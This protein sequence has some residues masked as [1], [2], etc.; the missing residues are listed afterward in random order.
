MKHPWNMLR[1]AEIAGATQA[2]VASGVQ[3]SI[4]VAGTDQNAV[5]SSQQWQSAW[6]T[7]PSW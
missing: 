1:S 3:L 6:A 4:D 2:E 5:A 7:S